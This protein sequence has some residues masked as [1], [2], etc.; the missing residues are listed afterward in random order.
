M[1]NP[2][3]NENLPLLTIL[4]G[5]QGSGKSTWAEKQKSENNKVVLSSDKIRQECPNWIN[6][7]VF[8]ELYKRA[9]YWLSKNI[10]V[11]IDS[12]AITIKTRRKMLDA[13]KVPCIKKVL[14]FN[15]PYEE[16]K[17]R[18]IQRNTINGKASSH[19]VPL[20]VQRQYLE[21]FEIPFVEEGFNY[22]D[23]YNK[24]SL[25][26]S[27]VNSDYIIQKAYKFNQNNKYHTKTLD[28]HMNATY[29]YLKQLDVQNKDMSALMASSYHDIG[30]IFTQTYKEGDPNAHYYNHANV[31]AYW[32]LS[33]IGIYE[34]SNAGEYEEDM[35]SIRKVLDTVFY[36][37]YHMKMYDLKTEKSI[38]KWKRIFGDVK[39]HNLELLHEAD[40]NSHKI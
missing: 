39:F 9:N 17:R 13:I 4:V 29:N 8:K 19:Y 30:K 33:N 18:L 40:M 3:T 28:E 24:P 35:Y 27:T 10:G 23:V 21:S 26:E 34:E 36:I 1:I 14:I 15:T 31:G 7:D 11:I 20:E 38:N 25:I 6:D 37:N 16:C 5:I 22:I 32:F 12:T 2:E